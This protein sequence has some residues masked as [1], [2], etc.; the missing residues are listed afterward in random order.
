MKVNLEGY[1]FGTFLW[2]KF[3]LDKQLKMLRTQTALGRG[4]TRLTKII[5]YV[6]TREFAK[7]GPRRWLVEEDASDHRYL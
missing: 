2:S 6:S 3:S 5:D 4:Q 1:V 7:Y